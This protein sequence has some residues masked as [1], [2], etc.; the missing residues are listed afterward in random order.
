MRNKYLLRGIAFLFLLTLLPFAAMAE[1]SASPNEDIKVLSESQT[2]YSSIRSAAVLGDTVYVLNPEGI[3]S[4][5]S[6]QA[7]FTLAASHNQLEQ[8]SLPEEERK[9]T[10]SILLSD[11]QQLWGMDGSNARLFTLDIS[12]GEL[13]FGEPVSLQMQDRTQTYETDA[14]V[15]HSYMDMPEQALLMNGQLYCLFNNYQNNTQNRTLMSYDIATGEAASY[16]SEFITGIA[17]YKDGKLL[18]S[19]RDEDNNYDSATSAFVPTALGVFD[20]QSDTI[21][22][23]G[24]FADPNAGNMGMGMTIKYE[25]DKDAVLYLIG[26]GVVRRLPDGTEEKCAY[27]PTRE[28]WGGTGD[29]MPLLPD[30]RVALCVGDTMHVRSTNPADLPATSL[31][32]YGGEENNAHKAALQNMPDVSVTA[33]QNKWFSSAQE[34][35]Q[36]LVSGEDGIDILFIETGWMDV[37]NLLVKGYAADLSASPVFQ[38]HM[39]KLYPQMKEVGM[40]DG[41]I[42]ALPVRLN[43]ESMS[44]NSK[45]FAKLGMPLPATYGEVCQSVKTFYEEHAQEGEYNINMQTGSGW[46]KDL[47]LST[48]TDYM[49]YK[50][51]EMTLDTPLFRQ[52]AEAL[53]SVNTQLM[54]DDEVDF[55]NNEDMNEFFQRPTLFTQGYSFD[56]QSYEYFLNRPDGNDM[57]AP[58]MFFGMKAD[59]DAPPVVKGSAVVMII[60]SQSKNMDAALRYAENYIKGLDALSKVTFYPGENEPIINPDHERVVANF[61][62]QL[63][64]MKVALEKAEGAEKTEMEATIKQM[65]ENFAQYNEYGKFLAS[66]AAIAAY[67]QLM[68]N[69]YIATYKTNMLMS[70]QDLSELRERYFG[71]QLSLDQF[72]QESDAKLRLIRLENQ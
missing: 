12:G 15:E 40:Q 13:V 21:E 68:E 72:I 11:G 59:Q 71:G 60:N 42:L 18:V 8:L 36:A 61:S 52:M 10:I 20:P 4:W 34:L 39:D 5:L 49:A 56:L 7:A 24:T 16:D 69:S 35:G 14:G 9:P 19:V 6:G 53:A 26:N 66:T 46:L 50:G 32:I 30:G 64:A 65:E 28:F 48:Y 22:E 57:S 23:I 67:R 1:A 54:D 27:L 43:I 17:A 31:V 33:L 38:E 58:D 29:K 25:K 62:Q 41:K 44:L 47:L 3:Y 51:E 63:A 55:S 2:G 70:Q 37:A 45:A